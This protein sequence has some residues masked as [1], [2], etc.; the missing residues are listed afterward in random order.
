MHFYN[1][2]GY[3]RLK[4]LKNI[5]FKKTLPF[6]KLVQCNICKWSGRKFLDHNWNKKVVCPQCQS[7]TRH[8]LL[9]LS[10]KTINIEDK[11]ILH[12]APE[13]CLK[14]IF[15]RTKNY[16]TADLVNSENLDFKI[17]ISNMFTINDNEYDVVIASDVLEHVYDDKKAIKE[18]NRILKIQ[19]IAVLTVPQGDNLK[20]T[21]EDLT[22]MSKK[23]RELKF[24]TYDHYRFYGSDFKKMLENE[25]FSVKTFEAKTFGYK[26][27]KY[28]VLRPPIIN[29]NPLATNRRRIYHATKF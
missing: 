6:P 22:N 17:D 1:I 4:H 25:K 20:H 7:D 9:H 3:W 2:R 15:E 21:I 8:R 19:G 29:T 28:H 26:I 14:K 24:G 18:I 13:D 12:F 5:I 10:L 16:K 11:K 27:S 23:E